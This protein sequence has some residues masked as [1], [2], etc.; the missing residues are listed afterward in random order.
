[1]SWDDKSHDEALARALEWFESGEPP[2]E[3]TA[4]QA[5]SQEQSQELSQELVASYLETLGAL[6]LALEPVEPP[7]EIR[8]NL[9]RTI[10]LSAE[11][12]ASAERPES[13]ARPE[14][15]ERP[16]SSEMQS[17]TEA[18]S[19]TGT[20]TPFRR[21][22]GVRPAHRSSWASA[23]AAA[24]SIGVLGLAFYAFQVNQRLES[25]EKSLAEL[26]HAVLVGHLEAE[27]TAAAQHLGDFQQRFP[28]V[29][30]SRSKLFPLRGTDQNSFR[31]A[32]FVC[33]KHQQWYVNLRGLT[34]AGSGQEYH[35]WFLTDSGPVALGPIQIQSDQPYEVSAQRMPPGTQG[36]IVS[37]ETRG[38]AASQPA[39]NIVLEGKTSIEI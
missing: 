34:P 14:S 39:G 18:A 2:A 20:V 26:T 29:Q 9:L 32:M 10:R 19:S 30:V 12:P 5:R 8:E 17:P 11:R 22:S 28:A 27:A 6:P 3:E 31:G 25:Q 24:L 4:S 15:A 33:A 21:P 23:L 35:L 13:A 16:P 37:L 1:M 38:Q 7:P 36:V